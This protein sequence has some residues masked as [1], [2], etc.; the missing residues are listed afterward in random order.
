MNASVRGTG[1]R[2]SLDASSKRKRHLFLP[3]AKYRAASSLFADSNARDATSLL[4]R[5]LIF[6]LILSLSI[7]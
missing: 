4:N 3:L 5:M 2:V 7:E 6:L 1:H